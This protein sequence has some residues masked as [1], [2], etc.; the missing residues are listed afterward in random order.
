[1]ILS[2]VYGILILIF[3]VTLLANGDAAIRWIGDGTS[4]EQRPKMPG[5]CKKYVRYFIDYGNLCSWIS[6]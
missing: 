4:Q 6:Q 3:C 2:T 5:S 1:M